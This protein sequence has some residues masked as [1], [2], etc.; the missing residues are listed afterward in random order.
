MKTDLYKKDFYA[1]TMKNANLL[2]N[3]RFADID[4]EHIVE[5]LISM[6]RSEQREFV[7]RLAILI[8]HLL[9]WQCQA[10]FQSKSW[11]FTIKEQRRALLRFLKDSPSLKNHDLHDKLVDAYKDAILLVCKDTGLDEDLFPEILPY[12]FDQ[13]MDTIFY[14]E[15]H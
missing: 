6:G 7:A 3:H 8:A 15:H 12:T 11:Q 5:E 9:K 13:L 14:P 1:W 2:S 4:V 10:N